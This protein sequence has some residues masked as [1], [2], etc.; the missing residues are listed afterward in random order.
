M[1]YWSFG[2][3]VNSGGSGALAGALTGSGNLT[4]SGA[5]AGALVN[6]GNLTGSGALAGWG[7]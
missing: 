3:L 2:A 7:L 5:L 6:S 4:G 1:D